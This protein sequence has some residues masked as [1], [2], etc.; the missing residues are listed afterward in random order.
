M[1]ET[2]FRPRAGLA[3][4]LVLG[5]C[6]AVSAGYKAKPWAPRALQT[7]AAKLASEGVTI[8]VDPLYRD[9]LAAQVFD[10]S[11]MVTRG[12]MPLGVIIFNDNDFPV[13]IRFTSIE[14]IH[15]DEHLHTLTP[16]EVAHRLFAKGNKGSWIPQPIPRKTTGDGVNR[17][18]L[19]DFDHKFLG[20]KTVEPHSQGGGFLYLHIPSDK[21]EPYLAG[22]RLYIPD[23][24]RQDK[25]EKMIFFEIELK[26]VFEA[27]ADELVSPA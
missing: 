5:T 8:A 18:A 22:S 13:M 12:I 14:L 17:D 20:D 16:N 27:A 25:A 23:V 26:P 10:K 1:S 2:R 6:A 9:T 11:D 15:A 21:I 24:Y 4:V 19:D 3:V 7:Y